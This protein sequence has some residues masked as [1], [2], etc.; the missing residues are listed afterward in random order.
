M[1]EEAIIRRVM[2]HD[3]LAE[4]S[5]L[6]A[7]MMDNDVLPDV[8]DTLTEDDFYDKTCQKMF[9]A[10][11]ELYREAKP[12][13]PV[14]L[15]DKMNSMGVPADMR[16]PE[17]IGQIVNAV[18]TSAY[19]G[20]YIKIV[21][22]KSYSRQI[23]RFAEGLM[24]RGYKDENAHDLIQSAE[25]EV[26]RLSQSFTSNTHK[27]GTMYE[28]MMKTLASIEAAA[29][30]GGRV[31]GIPTG[32]RDLDY[33]IAG[34]QPSDLILIAARPSMGKT[35]FALNIAMNAALKSNISTVI[36]SLEM[37]S[38]LLAKR[39]LSMQSGVD[40][41]KI[42]T[43]QL[44][45]NEWKEISMGANQFS[46]SDIIIDDTPGITLTQLRTKCRKLKAQHD[47]K[48]VFIDY[49]QLMVGEGRVNGRQEEISNI[50][51][52]LKS[53]ARELE[54]PIVA[55]SQLSR[56]PESRNDK[57]PMLSDLRES[58]AIEQD[59]DV[60]MFLY[61]DEYYNKDQ[62]EEKLKGITEVIIGKQRNGPVGTV[63]LKW[64]EHLTKF[65]NLDHEEKKKFDD[66]E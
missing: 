41:Q 49:L 19:V 48:L 12:V 40:S 14:T 13:D 37:S 52:G 59:A 30:S 64:L 11:R 7:V 24:E 9:Q 63:R 57:R 21:R 36:F 26:F 46:K 3:P 31:T 22:G 15:S 45:I 8:C 20:E 5:V 17:L 42:R 53:I 58:G 61:R 43:G 2:P 44:S 54:C 51:R 29:N 34:L 50:S 62:T 23:I 10:I 38:E 25:S 60:V 27:E 35:A 6:S 33:Q 55:L 56:G 4:R 66:E 18:P 1:E 39:L 32:F 47:I 65:G 28:I 16:S